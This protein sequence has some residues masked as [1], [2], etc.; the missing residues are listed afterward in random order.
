[1]S[2]NLK[3]IIF[4]LILALSAETT[5]YAKTADPQTEAEGPGVATWQSLFSPRI[6]ETVAETSS[7]P[8]IE[9]VPETEAETE[10]QTQSAESSVE[11][12]A[13]NGAENGAE[14]IALPDLP[15]IEERAAADLLLTEQERPKTGEL[16]HSKHFYSSSATVNISNLG[17]NDTVIRFYSPEEELV[18]SVYVRAGERL[19]VQIPGGDYRMNQAF[20]ERWYG[21]EDLFGSCGRYCICTIGDNPLFKIKRSGKYV[22]STMGQGDAFSKVEVTKDKF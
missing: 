15:S 17:E 12:N 2:K 14:V 20:G 10:A 11:N 8:L 21:K 13:E 1:M 19:K 16:F 6:P 3:L 5:A 4:I 7:K 22:I 9:T 18:F